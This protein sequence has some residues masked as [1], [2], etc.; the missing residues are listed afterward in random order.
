MKTLGFDKI[1]IESETG[2]QPTVVANGPIMNVISSSDVE[3]Y[4]SRTL[5]PLG[6]SL[7]PWLGVGKDL[8]EPT[9]L[10]NY[11]RLETLASGAAHR[12]RITRQTADPG[13]P[14]QYEVLVDAATSMIT[15]VSYLREAPAGRNL[16]VLVEFR[17]SNF[18]KVNGF[19]IP[20]LVTQF[21]RGQKAVE[22]QVL[23]FAVNQ[24]AQLADFEVKAQ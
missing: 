8:Y 15:S 20:T 22:I 23:S 4:S 13:S 11:V 3:V 17:F 10:K 12:I 1:R 21:I 6:V 9:S 14:Q 7:V 18:Q 5:G 19:V 16:T 2:T 24:G